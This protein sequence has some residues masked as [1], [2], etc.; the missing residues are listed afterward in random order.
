MRQR[1]DLDHKAK[2]IK[3]YDALTPLMNELRLGQEVA[4]IYTEYT[5]TSS[6]K[7]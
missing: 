1:R 3:V 2:P 6:K 5:L 4:I 7:Q